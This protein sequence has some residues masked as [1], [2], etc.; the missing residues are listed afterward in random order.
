MLIADVSHKILQG[1]SVLD[2]MYQIYN[3]CRGGPQFKELVAKQ[4]IGQI[5]LTRYNNKTYRVDD[6]D[7]NQ[8]PNSS[9]K[10]SDQTEITYVQYYKQAYDIEIK[11]LKQPLL[12][13]MPKA[14]D[15]RRG[16]EGPLSILP[17]LSSLTGLADDVRQ[18]FNIMKDLA[19]HTRIG[20]GDRCKRLQQF[21]AEINRNPQSVTELRNWNLEF[22]QTLL[23]MPGRLLPTEKIYQTNANST[24]TYNKDSADWSREMRG[25]PLLKPVQLSNWVMLFT[26]RDQGSANDLCT[27]LQKIG[28]PMGMNIARANMIQLPDDSTNTYLRALKDCVRPDINMGVAILPSNRKDRYDAIKSYCCVE[29][30]VPSQV[31]LARTLSKKQMLMSVATKIGIQL[32]CKM[33]GEV[34]ALD[35][36]LKKIMVVGIDTYHDS[37][38][39]GRSVGAFIASMNSTLTRY[40]SRCAF[41]SSHEELQNALRICMQ[42]A[43]KNFHQINGELPEKIIVFRDG[44]GDGQLATVHEHEV[45]QLLDCFQAVGPDYNPKCAVVVVTKRISSRFFLSDRGAVNNPLPGTVIDTEATRPEWYDF[46]IVSQSVRQGTVSPTHYNVIHDTTGLRPDHMQRL[47]YKLCHLYYN[48]PGT[49]RV[50]APCQ[51]AHKMAFL[52]GQSL[53]KDPSLAL[54]DKLFYL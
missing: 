33:G 28:P 38:K 49:I 36:P 20:P 24:Y 53:H 32:N 34:W 40:Y 26:Q 1:Q 18:D 5:V 14:K 41:Q 12:L 9:F 27:T 17:E 46:F 25:Q 15:R 22:S 44:V 54:A 37:L 7:W 50:P 8:S 23:D 35:I 21:I 2:K 29:N 19:I 6:I 51:Y 43:L 52:V 3:A 31:V 16:Q 42:A 4:I 47:A 13:S 39:K 30:P 48:W 11:D 10:K 45:K